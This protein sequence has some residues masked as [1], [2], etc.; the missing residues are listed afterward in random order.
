MET[1]GTLIEQIEI[2]RAEMVDRYVT[3]DR[4]NAVKISQ[5]LDR[6]INDYIRKYK[7]N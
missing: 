5:K 2:L 6:K 4:E 3:K 1:G 7:S